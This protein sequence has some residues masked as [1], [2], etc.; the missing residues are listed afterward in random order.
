MFIRT[1]LNEQ[2]KAAGCLD[3]AGS[4]VMLVTLDI[5]GLPGCNSALEGTCSGCSFGA[6]PM[7][8]AISGSR[9]HGMSAIGGLIFL[10]DPISFVIIE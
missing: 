8:G 7:S 9:R 10:V 3:D 5:A 1:D 2:T 6:P 4:H